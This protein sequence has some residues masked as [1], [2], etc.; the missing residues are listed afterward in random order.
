LPPLC[1]PSLLPYCCGSFCLQATM[2]AEPAAKKAKLEPTSGPPL[3]KPSF[4]VT[5]K[6]FIVTGGTQGLGL[7]IA[8][9][10]KDCGAA[11]L[12]L[13]SRSREKGEAAAAEL[14]GGSCTATFVQADLGDASSCQAGGKQAIET[15][16]QVHGLV[17]AAGITDRGNL[18]TTTVEEFDKQFNMNTRAPFLLTQ[19]VSKHMIEK[20]VRGAVVN[21]GSIAA[22]GG[23]PFIMAY[24]A[25]K[26]AVNVLAKNNAA[27]LAPHGIR[28][29]SID[30]GWTATDNE[31]V[32]QAKNGGPNWLEKAD[33]SVP[34]Q[35][36]MRPVDVA[37]V[38]CFL[39]SPA[40]QMMTGTILDL[41]PDTMLGMLSMKAVDSIDR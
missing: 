5:G 39:L 8:R 6:N 16:G 21:I 15:L 34:L 9:Q 22:K 31:A 17:N 10:L 11:K 4:D 7:E 12:A 29:N 36:I 35:R 23:A 24:S 1:H 14:T 26:A 37:C 32:L 30:M 28:V 40:S 13:L 20:G 25:S 18:M 19:A 27:E 38:A 3:S 33:S 41:H 2:T